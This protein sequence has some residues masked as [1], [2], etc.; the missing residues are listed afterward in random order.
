MAGYGRRIFRGNVKGM[1]KILTNEQVTKTGYYWYRPNIN[2]PWVIIEVKIQNNVLSSGRL[3]LV[4]KSNKNF[5]K[6]GQF[7]GPIEQ[8]EDFK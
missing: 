7:I 4:C 5:E 3:P 8:P 2:W 1:N 6:T